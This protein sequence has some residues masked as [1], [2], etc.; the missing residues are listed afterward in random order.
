V[1]FAIGSNHDETMKGAPDIATESAYTDA[2]WNM[3]AGVGLA[4][5][6]LERYPLADFDSPLDAWVAVTTDLRFSCPVRRIA[7]AAAASQEEPVYRYWFSRWLNLPDGTDTGALH[8]LELLFVFQTFGSTTYVTNATDLALSDA[9]IGY[10]TRFAATG[11]PG[12]EVQWP[13][14]VPELDPYLHLHGAPSTGT[15]LRRL[16]CDF[17][18]DAAGAIA[19][20]GG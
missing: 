9:M 15:Q 6:V 11:D 19:G 17:W 10:W 4:S 20:G 16:K 7:R 12:G 2:I 5:E 3:F 14:Y 18:D 1:P 13:V 8:G